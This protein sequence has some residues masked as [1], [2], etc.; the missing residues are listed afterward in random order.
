MAVSQRGIAKAAPSPRLE[1]FQR[2][3]RSARCYAAPSR[4]GEEDM[5]PFNFGTE[6]TAYAMGERG[7]RPRS[8]YARGPLRCRVRARGLGSWLARQGRPITRKI[9]GPR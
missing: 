4:L 1:L 6:E 5:H 9:C 2:D 7:F 3:A 8:G